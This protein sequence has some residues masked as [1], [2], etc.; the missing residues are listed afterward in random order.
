MSQ[1]INTV[2]AFKAL[3]VFA[4]SCDTSRTTLC[5]ALIKA[6]ITTLEEARPVVVEWAGMRNKCPRVDGKRSA[7]GR[8]VLQK[9]RIDG[10]QHPNYE[11]ARKSFQRAMGAFKPAKRAEKPANK[12]EPAPL[13]RTQ[14][15]ALR[16]ALAACDG[17]IS[18]VIA[19]LKA[20]SA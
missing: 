12:R 20:L 4:A 2:A 1:A 3:D 16:A 5:A 18:A 9:T 11:A 7:E 13:S 15:V 10:T 19:G 6:G 8:K 17:K 14:I